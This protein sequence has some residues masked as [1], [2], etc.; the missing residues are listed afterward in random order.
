M[1]TTADQLREEGREEEIIKSI[2]LMY[3]MKFNYNPSDDLIKILKNSNVEKLQKV[4]NMIPEI[5]SA[6]EFEEFIRE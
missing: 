5:D 4:R 2:K 1:K 3:K 6:K